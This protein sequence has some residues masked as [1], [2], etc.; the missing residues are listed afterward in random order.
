MKVFLKVV[1]YFI[2]I[3]LALFLYFKST[4]ERKPVYV[5][6]HDPVTIYDYVVANP[7]ITFLLLTH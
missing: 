2:P 3:A 5:F 1:S 4:K 6:K 7:K